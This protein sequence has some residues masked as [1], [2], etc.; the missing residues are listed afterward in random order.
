[1]WQ[2]LSRLRSVFYQYLVDASVL[3]KAPGSLPFLILETIQRLLPL[4]LLCPAT[5]AQ[6]VPLTYI[7]QSDI[8]FIFV[9]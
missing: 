6:K 2:S 5:T 4:S 1:M 7:L 3:L 8:L 9:L